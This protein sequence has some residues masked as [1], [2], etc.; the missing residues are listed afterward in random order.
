MKP[1]DFL[2][3]V[4]GIF[5]ASINASHKNVPEPHIGS[6]KGLFK[7]QPLK[8]NIPAAKTSFSGAIPVMVLYP[9]LNKESPEVFQSKFTWSWEILTK[10]LWSGFSL[11]T[12]GRYQFSY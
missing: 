4:G 3:I 6:I 10:N 9:L 12:L 8:F 1:K 7:S 5:L 11:S 2:L